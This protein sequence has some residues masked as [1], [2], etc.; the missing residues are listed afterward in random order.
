MQHNTL[1]DNLQDQI[2][3]EEVTDTKVKIIAINKIAEMMLKKPEN[4]TIVQKFLSEILGR[5]VMIEVKFE[6]KEN[7]FSRKLG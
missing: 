1:R 7:Y 6:N 4:I 2:A 5:E 3:I